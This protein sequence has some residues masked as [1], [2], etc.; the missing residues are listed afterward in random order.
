VFLSWFRCGLL[1]LFAYL[2]HCNSIPTQLL[3]RNHNPSPSL[4]VTAALSAGARSLLLLTSD[5][6][7]PLLEAVLAATLATSTPPTA[8]VCIAVL[9]AQ[10]AASRS[11][12]LHALYAA[13]P[14]GAGPFAG[15]L[16]PVGALASPEPAAAPLVEPSSA[17]ALP[18]QLMEAPATAPAA[19]LA[20]PAPAA[21]TPDAAAQV[22][23]IVAAVVADLLGSGAAPLPPDEPLMAAGVNSSLA[24]MLTGRLEERLGVVLP[25][26]LVRVKLPGL[27]VAC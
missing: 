15:V 12:L 23:Q 17:T 16:L 11:R 14:A 27:G 13:R 26:T 21:A 20:A 9:D 5:T 7:T 19:A 18:L 3:N 1:F 22:E 24:V 2:Y 6:P 10:A 8:S 4:K 25:P